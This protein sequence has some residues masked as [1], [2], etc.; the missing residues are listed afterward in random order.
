MV[1]GG[2]VIFGRGGGGDDGNLSL[3]SKHLSWCFIGEIF[4]SP[5]PIAVSHI[6]FHLVLVS[7]IGVHL[8]LVSHVFFISYLVCLS[9]NGSVII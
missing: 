1:G 9:H 8:V 4:L 3:L 6:G 5:S 7:H 2:S